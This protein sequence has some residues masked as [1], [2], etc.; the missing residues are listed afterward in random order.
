VNGEPAR[1]PNGE[2]RMLQ[3]LLAAAAL[4]AF[5]YLLYV[6]FRP[7]FTD[8]GW[9]VIL[10]LVLY[11]AHRRLRRK[12]GRFENL[13][14]G[15]SSVLTALLIL[16]PGA[17]LAL[18]FVGQVVEYA[19]RASAVVA[20]YRVE[21]V[22]DIVRIPLLSRIL[23][24]LTSHLPVNADQLQQWAIRS[25]KN[26]SAGAASLISGFLLDIARSVF[27]FVLVLFILFFL[28]RDGETMALRG[29]NLLP[30]EPKRRDALVAR[31]SAVLSAIVYGTLLTALFQGTVGGVIW[32]VFGLPAPVVFG[33]LMAF[34]SLLPVGGT[35]LVWAPAAVILAAQGSWGRAIG[36]ALTSLVFVGLADNWLRP[37][38]ISGRSKMNTLPVFFG[39][40]GGIAAFGMIGTFVG[41]VLL[42]LAFAFLDWLEQDREAS[43]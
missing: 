39:V 43:A 8:I 2:T 26:V 5:F 4:A 30:I 23:E 31:L 33:A 11:P 34:F 21:S 25:L 15:L 7:F 1:P 18:A 20:R 27:D 29:R 22:A 38:L 3:T 16:L 12:M 17:V 13:S 42:A 19:P 9:A 28:F 14:A 35:A 41:P 37:K 10:V 6:V 24:W 36:L 40:M 32:A